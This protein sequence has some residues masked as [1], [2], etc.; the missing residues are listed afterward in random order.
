MLLA[1]SKRAC[2]SICTTTFLPFFAAFMSELITCEFF[3]KRYNVIFIVVTFGSNAASRK[4]LTTYEND[5]YGALIKKSRSAM[6]SKILPSRL[7][8]F[9]CNGVLFLY[10]K[11]KRPRFGKSM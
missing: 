10:N 1:S 11:S 5:W 2:S 4:N 3:A 9:T 7:K 8:P 6:R